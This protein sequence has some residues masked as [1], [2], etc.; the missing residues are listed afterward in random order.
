MIWSNTNFLCKVSACC[1]CNHDWLPTRMNK[2]AP[3]A[4]DPFLN[5]CTWKIRLRS[6]ALCLN[7]TSVVWCIYP[8]N[9]PQNHMTLMLRLTSHPQTIWLFIS[10]QSLICNMWLSRIYRVLCNVPSH[11]S[12]RQVPRLDILIAWWLGTRMMNPSSS[13]LG[14]IR[15]LSLFYW[16]GA[17]TVLFSL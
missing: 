14:F 4:R 9:H 13:F 3:H 5:P 1:I 15:F 8:S 7:M 6:P 11:F 17:V 16:R 10:Y 2:P 12:R